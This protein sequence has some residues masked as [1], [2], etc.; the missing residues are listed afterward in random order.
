MMTPNECP[1]E[2]CNKFQLG[3]FLVPTREEGGTTH[4]KLARM[5]YL[6]IFGTEAEVPMN[7]AHEELQ[8]YLGSCDKE[9]Q[10]DKVWT[11]SL[12]FERMDLNSL[13]HRDYKLQVT[14]T[15]IL[16]V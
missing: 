10:K 5:L 1:N 14:S 8:L 6:H 2:G 3:R 15:I 4:H 7:K 13:S 16:E 9:A 11:Y 12:Y